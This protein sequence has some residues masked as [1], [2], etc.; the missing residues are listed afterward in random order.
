MAIKA[1]RKTITM[2]AATGSVA[3][4]LG[5]A[6][7]RVLRLEVK[8]DDADVNAATTFAITD[9]DGKLVLK[10]VAIDGGTD[11][12]VVKD[13]NDDYSTVGLGYALVN[14]EAKSLLSSGAVG[15]DNVGGGP[16][17]ARSPVTVALA[18]GTPGDAFQITLIVEV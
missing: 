18:S 1:R 10:A 7:A 12:S 14:D 17:I 4:G 8:G 5:A 15:T 11:D 9:A 2:A 6:F 16:S 3:I 13:T